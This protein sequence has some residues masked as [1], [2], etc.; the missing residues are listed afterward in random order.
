M[1]IT[2]LSDLFFNALRGPMTI[3]STAVCTLGSE[4]VEV[5]GWPGGLPITGGQIQLDCTNRARRQ[6]TCTIGD[7][8]LAPYAVTD[9]LGIPGLELTIQQTV[10]YPDG[11]TETCPLG[12]F[13]IEESDATVSYQQPFTIEQAPD[14]GAFLTDA[15]F[16]G[17]VQSYTGS[18]VANIGTLM[19]QGLPPG[20]P[21][22]TFVDLTGSSFVCPQLT[23]TD[24]D[25]WTA[26]GQLEDSIGGE[27]FFDAI[28][29]PTVRLV[30]AKTDPPVW[31]VNAGPGGVMV[32]A[33]RK[34]GRT[35]TFNAWVVRG[36]RTDGTVAAQALV[37]DNDTL[38]PT[39][40]GGPFGYKPRFYSSPTVSTYTQALALGN[41]LLSQSTG[42]T[43][44]I[45]IT[46]VPNPAL[47]GSD[48]ITVVYPNG[49]E[50]FAIIDQMTV[51]LAPTD[52]QT[53][54]TRTYIP[55]AES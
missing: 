1:M 13:H 12:V 37:T 28:G 8:D 31:T 42:Q 19:S 18:A 15:R 53:I 48:V 21:H 51:G 38:S 50:E 6:L 7:P 20:L 24:P 46:N 22:S 3:V 34:I 29:Q 54:T 14:R 10:T 40:W 45:D 33:I 4:V 25:R 16:T 2:G 36:M 17:T 49:F 32:E 47:E 55:P 41:V 27:A 44:E 23:W 9:L 35:Q 5:P 30:A 52:P 11:T 26:I 43:K 39:Y